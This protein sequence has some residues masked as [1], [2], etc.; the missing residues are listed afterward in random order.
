MATTKNYLGR[1]WLRKPQM[2]V[3]EFVEANDY[4]FADL[5]AEHYPKKT[6]NQFEHTQDFIDRCVE[7]SFEIM[8]M[9]YDEQLRD[10]L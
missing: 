2:T 7:E 9:F 4:I 10:N 3:N 1:R 8:R 5:Y 6:E